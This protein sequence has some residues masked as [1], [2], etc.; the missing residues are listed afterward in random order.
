ME[1]LARSF[2]PAAELDITDRQHEG[3]VKT[4]HHFE[5]NKPLVYTSTVRGSSPLNRSYVMRIQPT[6]I[7]VCGVVERL[8]AWAATR[9]I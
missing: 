7:S 3:L 9:L 4:L 2:M 1:M 5:T 6:S 8:L